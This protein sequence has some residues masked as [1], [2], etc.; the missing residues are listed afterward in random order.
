MRR[1]F[2]TIT[3]SMLMTVC[4]SVSFAYEKEIKILSAVLM[5]KMAKAGKK[6]VAV[7]DLTDL[8]GNVT[9]LGRFLAE[10]ISS[11]LSS[12][13]AGFEIVDRAHLKS[14]FAEHKFSQSGLVDPGTIK[15]LGQIA[16]VDAIVTGTVTP[17]GDSIRISGKVIATDTAK[18]IAT[19]KGDIAKTKAIEELLEKGIES[20]EGTSAAQ[21]SPKPAQKSAKA[22]KRPKNS[23]AAAEINSDFLGSWAGTGKSA[24]SRTWPLTLSITREDSGNVTAKTDYPSFACGADLIL[25]KSDE[26]SME[27]L[28][29]LSYGH[30]KCFDKGVFSFKQLGPGF[31]EFTWTSENGG[32][33]ATGTL[34]LKN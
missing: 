14:I 33:I 24:N 17:F 5:E 13:A 11:E 1:F 4:A 16:G 29:I 21:S 23:S 25:K 19:A 18:V 26:N 28:E 8:Q 31:M 27:F 34:K 30:S 10:E 32:Q 7:V 12:G 9:E 20:G 2:I 3:V 22:A 15:Q 6:N